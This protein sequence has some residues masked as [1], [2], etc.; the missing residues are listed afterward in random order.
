MF[1][2]FTDILFTDHYEK[3]AQ[4][5]LVKGGRSTTATLFKNLIIPPAKSLVAG[6]F[7]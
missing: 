6:L 7:F 5:S 3:M 2:L 1:I 4:L